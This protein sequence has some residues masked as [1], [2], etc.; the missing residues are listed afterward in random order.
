MATINLV[1]TVP[2]AQLDRVR[3]G[4]KAFWGKIED[5]PGSGQFRDM[6]NAEVIE[7]LRKETIGNIKRMVLKA[8]TLAAEKAL[9]TISEVDAT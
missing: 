5:P 1:I 3:N 7:R 4:L 9:Q 8:E 2:D 6:T